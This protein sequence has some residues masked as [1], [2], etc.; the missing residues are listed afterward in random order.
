MALASALE[1]RGRLNEARKIYERALT[2]SPQEAQYHAFLADLL[3]R[4]RQSADAFASVERAIRLAPAFQ[5]AWELLSEWSTEAGEPERTADFARALAAERPGDMRVWLTVARVLTKPDAREER[6]A[7]VERA[8]ELDGRSTEAWDMK[9][10]LLA[11]AE[12]FDEAARACTDGAAACRGDVHILR[13][14]R[15]WI[16][17]SRRKLP[18][19]IGLMR[20]VLA[21]NASYV[22]GWQQL[23]GWLLEQ[24]ATAEATAAFEQ[25]QRLRPHDAWVNR[26]LGFLRVKQKDPAGAR[27]AFASAL[28]AEP[29]DAS[30]AHNLLELQLEASDLSGAAATL[31]VMQTHQPGA[32]TLAAETSVRLGQRE[33]AA[34]LKALEALCA[35]PD[36][37]SWP[38]DT[39]TAA[40]QRAGRTRKALKVFRRA[41]R[42]GSANPQ[43]GTA[44][45]ELLLAQR[46]CLARVASVLEVIYLRLDP[47][48]AQRRAAAPLIHGLAQNSC[49]ALTRWV[50]WRRREVL[51][52]D[53]AAWGQVG[54]ALSAFKRMKQ[55]ALWLGDWRQRGNTE[56]WMLFNLCLALRHLG[57]YDEATD[58]ARHV[59]QTRAHREGAEDMHV[60]LAVEEAIAGRAEEAAAHIQRAV[61]RKG[62]AYDEQ[63]IALARALV[64]FEQIPPEERQ[65]QSGSI[66]RQLATHFQAWTLL[67]SMRDVRR[68]FRRA[69]QRFHREGAG[70]ATRLWFAWRLNWQWLALPLSPLLLAVATWPPVM[71]GLIIAWFVRKRNRT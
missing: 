33:N 37:N 28:D 10:E 24:G 54:Y 20:A 42:S 6:L 65:R 35:S 48:E 18:E 56:P 16:E 52:R 8:I 64:E 70:T 17:A 57:R 60:F 11:V 49:R 2:H 59:V 12:R 53:D 25:M 68:T 36:P 55:G 47:G 45:I 13:G 27:K 71:V 9:A 26:Q 23:G 66:R 15:A 39:A 19:A 62:H 21:E 61:V 5:W 22:W 14:R 69:G 29:T 44:A 1:R 50:L 43:V 41:I 7:A 31:Q 4:L 30:A 38:I 40:F 34:A 32:A 46:S 3:R 67:Y 51:F 63:M 58:V